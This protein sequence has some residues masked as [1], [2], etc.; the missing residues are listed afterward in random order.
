MRTL[1]PSCFLL[2]PSEELFLVAKLNFFTQCSCYDLP[3]TRQGAALA[4]FDSLPFHNIVILADDSVPFLAK[5]SLVSW[6]YPHTVALRQPFL[7][8][9][10]QCVLGYSHKNISYSTSSRLV[11]VALTSLLFLFSSPLRPSLFPCNIFLF[12]VFPSFSS[13]QV[14]LA[15]NINF[16]LLYFY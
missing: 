2:L 6:P 4:H 16:L 9:L 1:L 5:E 8:W 12:H 15:G 10:V 13:S 11:L 14:H 7:N 3:L